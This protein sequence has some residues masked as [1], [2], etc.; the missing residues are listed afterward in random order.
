LIALAKER[1]VQVT[2][3]EWQAF[4][5]G[6]LLVAQIAFA[7]T[8]HVRPSYLVLLLIGLLVILIGLDRSREK[9][10]DDAQEP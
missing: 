6:G 7:V 5:L 4:I 2:K 10:A 8:G 9:K 3:R 1:L